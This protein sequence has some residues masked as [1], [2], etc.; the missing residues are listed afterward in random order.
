MATVSDHRMH[1]EREDVTVSGEFVEN[2]VTTQLIGA[3]QDSV[4]SAGHQMKTFFHTS[5]G[6]VYLF[7]EW[8]LSSASDTVIACLVLFVVAI[9]YEGIK[10][11][12]NQLLKKKY[13]HGNCYPVASQTASDSSNV[14]HDSR[15]WIRQMFSL[16]HVVSTLLH[17][18]QVTLGYALMLAIMT[19]NVWMVLAVVSGA[20]LGYFAFS[21]KRRAAASDS[22]VDN[23]YL[24]KSFVGDFNTTGFK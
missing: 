10:T 13:S 19:F 6:D 21:W 22:V 2:E 1:L 5:Y 14:C 12:Q 11:Y 18:V 7:K 4:A 15:P 8:I 9:A 16:I 24:N 20:G 23:C 17:V 3:D